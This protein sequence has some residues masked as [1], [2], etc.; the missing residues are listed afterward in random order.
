MISKRL[1]N[2]RGE[3]IAFE[4]LDAVCELIALSVLFCD[5]ECLRGAIDGGN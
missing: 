2:Q 3:K 4:E 5:G 1:A